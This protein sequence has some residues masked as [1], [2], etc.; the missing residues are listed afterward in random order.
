MT[1]MFDFTVQQVH[2]LTNCLKTL[3]IGVNVN[4]FIEFIKNVMNTLGFFLSYNIIAE[5]IHRYLNKR[6][7]RALERSPETVDF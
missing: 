3:A 2:K 4:F 1:K 7:Q 6:A 5:E